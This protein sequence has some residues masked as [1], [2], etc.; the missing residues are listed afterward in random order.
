MQTTDHRAEMMPD[1]TLSAVC[2]LF[3]VSC[4]IYIATKEGPESL[5]KLAKQFERP[6]EDIICHGCRADKRF[7]HCEENC[8][9]VACAAEK[10]VD[11]CGQ[12]AEY[13]CDELQTFQAAMPH[14]I[15]LWE[16]HQRIR[17]AGYETWYQE[18][19][20]HYS[21][22]ECHTINS[23]YDIACRS[24]GATPSCAYVGLHREQIE[25][26]MQRAQE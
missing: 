11:F 18:M 5:N 4:G 9:F 8:S 10:G 17:E 25:A 23:A 21:C 7:F 24:C 2:G 15:E 14:R 12:C 6:M 26:F 22:S 3:C 1:K 20:G 13:P 16:N 19:I